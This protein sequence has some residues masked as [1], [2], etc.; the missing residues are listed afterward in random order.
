MSH[1]QYSPFTIFEIQISIQFKS[2]SDSKSQIP[3]KIQSGPTHFGLWTSFPPSLSQATS[4]DIPLLP[5]SCTQSHL[6]FVEYWN[7]IALIALQ[8]IH[9]H[10]T[11]RQFRLAPLRLHCRVGNTD[12]TNDASPSYPTCTCYFSV[13]FVLVFLKEVYYMVLLY[14]EQVVSFV[15]LCLFI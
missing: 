5:G 12:L 6:Y 1:L 13:C 2:P 4:P 8:I 7:N 14:Q 3:R 15:S 11:P 9:Q 10:L